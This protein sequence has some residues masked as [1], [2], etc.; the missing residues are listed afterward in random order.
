MPEVDVPQFNAEDNMLD[1]DFDGARFEDEGE[2]L[3]VEVYE[4]AGTCYAGDGVTFLDLF[5]ADEYAECRKEN[6][7]YPFASKEEWEVADFLL[8]SPLSMA[9]I[10]QFLE[11]PMIHQLKLSFRNAKELRSHAEMLPKGPSWK[12]QA[13]PSPNPT[14]S[15]I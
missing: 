13:I 7:F 11:L 8:R 9:A 6:L 4:G 5:D 14:K 2:A 3:N 10:N 15:P 1:F 12:C